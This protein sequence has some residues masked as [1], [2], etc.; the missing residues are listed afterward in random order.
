MRERRKGS[1]GLWWF[2]F[3]ERRDEERYG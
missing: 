3:P 1:K 2:F